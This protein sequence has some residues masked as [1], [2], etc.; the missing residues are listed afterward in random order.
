MSLSFGLVPKVEH[1]SCM[2]DLCARAGLL[3]EAWD[4]I[5]KMPGKPDEIVLGSLL[6]ACLRCRIADV[7]ERVIQ[8]FLEMELSNS[9]NYVISSKIYANMKRWDD[10]AKMRVLMRQF[11]VSKTPGCSRIDIGARVHEFHAGDS[12]QHHLVII[13]QLLNEE[14]KREVEHVKLAPGTNKAAKPEKP[15]ATPVASSKDDESASEDEETQTEDLKAAVAKAMVVGAESESK[16]VEVEGAYCCAERVTKVVSSGNS[17]LLPG[18]LHSRKHG[19]RIHRIIITVTACVHAGLVDEGRQLF[20]SMSLSFRLVPKVEHY[21]CMVLFKKM[22]GKP[23]EIVLGSLL[24][25]CQRCRNAD[26]GDRV[27]QMFLEMKLS[28]SENYVISSK[29]YANMK[30]WDDCAKMR[31]LMKQSGVSKTPGCS[32]IGIGARV[33]EFHAGDSLHHHLVNIYQLL[34]EEMKREGYISYTDCI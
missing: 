9:G 32:W 6:G 3:Y 8:F 26:V 33:H 27:I 25:A 31:V 1:Y 28:N 29:I 15:Q 20:E 19:K 16:I 23:D 34:N 5:K 18:A 30:R 21:S 12:L 24:G 14:M 13:Y 7:G 2:V 17:V 4:L 22:P 11:G 10:C